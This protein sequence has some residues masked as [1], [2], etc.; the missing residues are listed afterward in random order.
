VFAKAFAI[1]W[2]GYFGLY[3]CRK[4]FSVLMPYLKSE[5]GLSSGDLANALFAYSLMYAI[6]Q[7]VMGR[8]ADRF[9]ARWVAGCGMLVSA[10]MSSLM[11][12]PAWI[13][14]AGALIAIQGVNGMAQASGWPSVLKLTRDWF[15]VGNRGVSMGWWSTHLVAGGFAG[16]WLAA[17]CAE[18]HW[19]LAAWVPSIAL[20]GIGLLFL[21]VA[22]DKVHVAG[23]GEPVARVAGK[24][25]ITP[26]LVAIA[27][28][29]FCVKMTRYAFLFWLPL[30]M[31]EY[32]KYDKPLAGYASS[33]Y[34][35]IGIFGALAA[36]YISERLHGAR[37]SVGAVM[38][39]LLALFCSTYPL[40]SA[41]GFIPNLVWIALIGI[42]TFGP[43]TL[44]AGAALQDAVPPESTAA[45]GGFVN[46]IGSVGQVISPWAVAYL[47]S[48]FGWEF[49]FGLLAVVVLC[50]GMALT[51]QWVKMP[52]AGDD[53]Q[54]AL[55]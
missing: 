46:G 29:Y 48:R 55:S 20:T 12:W 2:L 14:F 37:F 41:S 45:A 28:M 54:E 7:F 50:G 16:T 24:L 27:A 4:N 21:L 30:Y 51:T 15:P 22:R 34:E 39:F 3:L 31:T 10:L 43:D 36:G 35:L 38:M 13:G 40:V 53:K 47:S 18:T 44:M 9:G 23:D 32:L 8:M 26:P 6:G 52:T 5:T 25:K 1:S 33:V 49:L 11:A 17:R 42:F 19:T